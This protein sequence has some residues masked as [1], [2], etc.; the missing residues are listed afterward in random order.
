MCFPEPLSFLSNSD[1]ND[2]T[3]DLQP[4]CSNAAKY[5][6]TAGGETFELVVSA[7][8]YGL[9]NHVWVYVFFIY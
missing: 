4:D 5:I 6:A 1:L 3:I 2:S 7:I 8:Q 9:Q